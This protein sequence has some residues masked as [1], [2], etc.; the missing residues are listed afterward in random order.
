M[1][2]AL[3]FLGDASRSTRLWCRL[4]ARFMFGEAGF[5]SA[6]LSQTEALAAFP[7]KGA[8][9]LAPMARDLYGTPWPRR[10]NSPKIA[11]LP[12]TGSEARKT[13]HF[14]RNVITPRSAFA[15][16]QTP[17]QSVSTTARRMTPAATIPLVCALAGNGGMRLA[18]ILATIAALLVAM[19]VA[20]FARHSASPGSLYTYASAILPRWIGAIVAWTLSS[21]TLERERA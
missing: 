10:Y 4:E 17:A 19:C 7:T 9:C 16:L 15:R 11:I 12:R 14:I 18:Y 2:E 3:C 6:E 20:S 1:V 21:L 8:A 5:G 13:R